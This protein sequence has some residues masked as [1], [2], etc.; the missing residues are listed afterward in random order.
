MSSGIARPWIVLW[1]VVALVGAGL[2]IWWGIDALWGDDC[3]RFVARTDRA[4]LSVGL[5]VLS[6]PVGAWVATRRSPSLFASN[7]GQANY[8]TGA[9]VLLGLAAAIGG[10]VDL[11]DQPVIGELLG[12]TAGCGL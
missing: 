5:T 12:D 9:V 3:A 2:S 1:L 8:L 4:Q 10:S 7:T 11:Y 6:V